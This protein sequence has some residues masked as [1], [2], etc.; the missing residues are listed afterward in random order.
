MN[1]SQQQLFNSYHIHLYP[2]FIIVLENINNKTLECKINLFVPNE[3]WTKFYNKNIFNRKKQ[4][5]KY[6]IDLNKIISMEQIQ[7]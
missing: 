1:S 5:E 6:S 4:L 3:K 2:I 7:V